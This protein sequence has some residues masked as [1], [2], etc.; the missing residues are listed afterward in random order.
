M[1]CDCDFDFDCGGDGGEEGIGDGKRAGRGSS[2]VKVEVDE[3][4]GAEFEV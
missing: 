1:G 4:N 2:G 3:L